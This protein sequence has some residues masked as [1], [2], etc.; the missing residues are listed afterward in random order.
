MYFLYGD[1]TA[2]P[3]KSNFLEF[4][5]D[6][7]DF[8]VFVLEADERIKRGKA[9]I[10][11]LSD[12][13]EAELARLET[14]IRGV[15][16]TIEE[17]EKG[18]PESA[19]SQCAARLTGLVLETQRATV[20]AAQSRLADDIAR[21]NAEEASTREKCHEALGT[22]LAPHEP[23]DTSLVTRLVLVP[24]G[25]YS[26]TLRGDAAFGLE[27]ESELAIPDGSL[28]AS[29]VRV[30]RVTPQLEIRAPQLTGWISKEVK[31]RPQ[32]LERH[33]VT[34]LVDDG[35]KIAFKL[36]A[37]PGVE[38]GFDFE[39]EP[40][41][42]KVR[43]SRVGPANDASVG[44]FD[45]ADEDVG[46]LVD[47]A[48][49]LLASVEGFEVAELLATNVDGGEFR[50]MPT[51]VPFVE[52]LVAMLAPIVHE[53]SDRS[54][55]PTELVL[56]RALANDRRE[57]LFVA[58]ATLR[59]KY[60]NLP[61][62]LRALFAPLRLDPV[63]PAKRAAAAPPADGPPRAEIAPSRPPPPP[64][65]FRAGKSVRPRNG[66]SPQIDLEAPRAPLATAP[67]FPAP[68]V[69][70][71]PPSSAAVLP[72]VDSTPSN[73]ALAAT[74]KKIVTLTKN[75]RTDEAYE[76]F[77]NLFS[78][79]SFGDLPPDD[80]R[81][82]LRLLVLAKTPAAKGEALLDAHRAA[83]LRIRALVDALDEPGDHEMLGVTYLMFDDT[84]AAKASFEAALERARARDPESPL[85][86][87]IRKRMAEL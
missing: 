48:K 29:A 73:E 4:L 60:A 47:L 87:A 50:E 40:A 44:S 82:A 42:K 5:R 33:V 59:E 25:T 57:E 63:D 10:E 53:I 11:K 76:E 74:L 28:F 41:A 31:I 9:R 45:V 2:S 7:I 68:A 1:S 75:G 13:T 85:S 26:A 39:I 55:T 22:L 61:E 43:A 6:S 64:L 36:R 18:S 23:P 49:K 12:E 79:P 20:A 8:A 66:S 51:F 84:T 3:L 15:M 17:S 69:P 67:G 77:T 65:P 72:Q 34:E 71:A 16:R 80:Q 54:L 83:M 37:E 78:A 86:F 27:W 21:V 32:R 70:P 30:D 81:H 35:T 38:A 19:T 24:S 62:P 46:P 14:F 58:K 56:R 52:K